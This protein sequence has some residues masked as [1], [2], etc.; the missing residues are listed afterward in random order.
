MEDAPP[1]GMELVE[2][3]TELGCTGGFNT[4]F[5]CL[6]NMNQTASAKEVAL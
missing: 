3:V 6:D 1:A 5:E 4:C 2:G